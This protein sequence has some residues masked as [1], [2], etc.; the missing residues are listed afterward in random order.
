MF[1]NMSSYALYY[2]L[3]SMIS[4]LLSTLLLYSTGDGVLYA[5]LSDLTC[6]KKKMHAKEARE[7][8]ETKD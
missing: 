5:Y 1:S 8:K 3:S 7:T 6:V 2:T 4:T